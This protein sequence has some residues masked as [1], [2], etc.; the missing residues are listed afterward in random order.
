MFFF[1]KTSFYLIKTIFIR[2]ETIYCL[3]QDVL[4]EYLRPTGHFDPLKHKDLFN[5]STLILKPAKHLIFIKQC[6]KANE[7]WCTICITSKF[8]F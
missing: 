6:D 3:P 4:S 7:K 8:I 5:E 2:L 1:I